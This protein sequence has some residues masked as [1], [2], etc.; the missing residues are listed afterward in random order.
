V[1]ATLSAPDDWITEAVARR[2]PS[3]VGVRRHLH[4]HP[5]LSG[6][7]R[8]TAAFL[9]ERL[10]ELG[11]APELV[12]DGTGVVAELHG[13]AAPGATRRLL[14]RADIDALPIAEADDGRACRS[15]TEGVMHACGHDAHAAIA[16][17]AIG[18]LNE[19]RD[20]LAGSVLLVLQPDEERIRGARAMVEAGV[21]EGRAVDG[22]LG[23]HVLSQLEVGTVGVRPGVTFASVDQFTIE[24]VGVAGHGGLPHRALDPI[25]T[26]AA[27]VMQTQ[28]LIS[29]ECS[30]LDSAVVSF[31][32][33]HGGD[34]P[35]SIPGRVVLEGTIRA[36]DGPLRERLLA[37]I[38]Q[39]ARAIASAGGLEARFARGPG[40]PPVISDPAMADL[41]RRAAA[42]TP[43]AAVE[44]IGPLSVGDDMAELMALAPG[45]YFMLGAGCRTRGLQAPHHHPDFDVDERCLPLG[46]EVLARAALDFCAHG[47]GTGTDAGRRVS[48]VERRIDGRT[49]K[50]NSK[51]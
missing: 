47:A 10:G 31:G 7:E 24:V 17:G 4:E 8:A 40:V 36:F 29:R 34:G 2:T 46:A 14:L 22:V 15:R 12:L 9:A 11:L 16:I 6:A 38:E 39:M 35:T 49:I 5:E 19:H 23:L 21:F 33:I 18:V 50:T 20:Q 28:T 44:E 51:G 1:S 3:I 13:T 25:P 27:I 37:R 26:A 45:C 43:G 32:A 48:P 42:A 30:P 41:V